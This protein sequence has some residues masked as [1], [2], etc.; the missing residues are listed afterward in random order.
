MATVDYDMIMLHIVR[1][2]GLLEQ[3]KMAGLV[4]EDFS[5]SSVKHYQYVW[6]AACDY[7]DGHHAVL[8]QMIM[9]REVAQ[10][11]Q[12][13]ELVTD[14][15]LKRVWD[16]VSFIY[17]VDERELAP[18]YVRDQMLQQ[19]ID[20]LKIAPELQ[21][22]AGETEVA[23]VAEMFHN[24][25]RLYDETRIIVNKPA[26]LFSAAGRQ[27]HTNEQKPIPTGI[28]FIDLATG[29]LRPASLVGLLAESAGGKT[30]MGNQFL[31]ECALRDR[32][33]V[34]FF[35]EQS[36]AG[37]IAE[38]LYSYLSATPRK[39]LAGKTHE[40]YPARVRKILDGMESRMQKHL[41]VYDMSGAVRGQGN[42]GPDEIEVILGRMIRQGT[43]PEFVVVDWLLPLVTKYYKMPKNMRTAD[44][45]EK[46][47]LVLTRFNEIK[48]RYGI[49]ILLLNQIAAHIVEGKTPH[50]KPDWTVAAECKNFGFLMDYVFTFGR[51]CK[52]TQCMWFSTPKARGAPNA[53][54]I[55][56]MDAQL[57]KI[58][59]A[60]NFTEN[61]M[62]DRDKI[63]FH[64]RKRAIA[65][66]GSE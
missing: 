64:E 5:K 63:F 33:A 59:D 21:K 29:G 7:F 48:E 45:R 61:A 32:N 31:C 4:G 27:A 8:P 22:M 35:Y 12:E 6:A 3:A 30:M 13:E 1:N 24:N 34:G 65:R 46:I 60:N 50:Y 18:D 36:L 62:G 42:G 47:D 57:N 2:V 41:Q 26:D 11:L 20:E 51:K 49:T 19:M 40:E 53:H 55:V 56:R 15:T 43:R 10:A 58:Y 25:Q 23:V 44:K 38:R 52:E 39:D 66:P 16:L 28:D 54:R 37:D 17:S 9:D 14:R